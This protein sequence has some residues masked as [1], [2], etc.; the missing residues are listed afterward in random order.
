MSGMSEYIFDTETLD[1]FDSSV[2]LSLAIVK[3]PEDF[4]SF[5]YDSWNPEEDPF[6]PPESW[7]YFKVDRK[8]QIKLGRTIGKSTLK[9][10]DDQSPEAKEVLSSK[11]SIAPKEA[12]KKVVSFLVSSGFDRSDKI[13]SRRLF[14]T[15]LWE[16]FCRDF[17]SGI[18]PIKYWQ[19]LDTATFCSCF[20]S[21]DKAGISIADFPKFKEHVA[22]HDCFL[23]LLRIKK[24]ASAGEAARE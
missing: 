22:L 3:I 16:S 19:Y 17:G 12:W 21:S 6:L 1:R 4:S 10:W 24:I 23:D 8:D 18:N 11:N 13:F 14:E 15:K 20:S 7:I 2:I 5:D 9:W